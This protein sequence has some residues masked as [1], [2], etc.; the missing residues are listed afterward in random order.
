MWRTQFP[1]PPLCSSSLSVEVDD[2]VPVI[3]SHTEGMENRSVICAHVDGC[4][5]EI[6][7]RGR[8]T[9]HDTT[10]QDTTRWSEVSYRIVSYRRTVPR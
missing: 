10:R 6:Q 7:T 8:R 9:E 3:S 4:G 2:D 1:P 5:D